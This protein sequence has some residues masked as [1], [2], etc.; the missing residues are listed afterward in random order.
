[1]AKV[2]L[3]NAQLKASFETKGAELLSVRRKNMESG[4]LEEQEFLWSGDPNYWGRH[5][6][7]LFPFVGTQKGK[8]YQHKGITYGMTQH[9]F[10]RDKE[11]VIQTKEE[12]RIWF[13]LSS[14]EETIKCYPFEFTLWIGYELEENTIQVFYRVENHSEEK[15]YFAIGA[16]PGFCCPIE[17]GTSQ[18]D[19]SF[20]FPHTNTLSYSIVNMENG[21]KQKGINK[22]DLEKKEE[23]GYLKLEKGLF[24]RDALI[25]EESGIKEVA[26]CKA[27]KKPYVIVKFDTPLFGLWSPAGKNAPFVCIEPW[28]GRCDAEGFQGELREKEYINDLDKGELFERSYSMQFLS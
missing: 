19:Y 23:Y 5:A 7:I 3:E 6:P 10:A 27:D 4:E 9:G 8:Q 14:D 21:L 24:D 22:I 16:H 13:R 25:I 1:M 12:N 15:M 26:L 20:R 17:E 11:F 18:E 28:Y 2:Y